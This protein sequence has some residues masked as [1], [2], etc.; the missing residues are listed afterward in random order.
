MDP[1]KIREALGLAADASDGEVKAALV[2]AGL[3]NQPD[4]VPDPDPAPAPNAAPG[5]MQVS[6]SVWEE[7]QRTIANLTEFVQEARRGERD[8]VLAKAVEQGKFTPAQKTHFAKLWDA[9]PQ[10][11]RD[12]IDNLTPN[13]ALAVQAS[14]YDG[15][16]DGKAF[17]RE[18]AGL[19]P[20]G[21]FGKVG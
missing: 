16:I 15:D 3:A 19:F 12:L 14:G 21:F 20:N 13:T 10:G 7:Q 5:V 4:P 9:D 18:F 2:T 8:S 17:D 11:T 6:A 1:A